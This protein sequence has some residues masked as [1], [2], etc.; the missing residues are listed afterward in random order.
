M[1]TSK[2]ILRERFL[3]CVSAQRV[4]ANSA[5]NR[6]VFGQSERFLHLNGGGR[7]NVV[8]QAGKGVGGNNLDLVIFSAKV[9]LVAAQY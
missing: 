8:S 5:G 3:C 6:N 2:N 7:R 4:D 9:M 1:Y